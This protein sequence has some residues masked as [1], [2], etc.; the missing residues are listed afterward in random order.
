VVLFNHTTEVHWYRVSD[1][2]LPSAQIQPFF[3]HNRKISQLSSEYGSLFSLDQSILSAGY[4]A[5]ACS[6]PISKNVFTV[7]A[8]QKEADT[9]AAADVHPPDQRNA[10]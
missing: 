7:D 6:Q 9:S 8:H 10:G 1:L 2:A 3:I 5:S 4:G